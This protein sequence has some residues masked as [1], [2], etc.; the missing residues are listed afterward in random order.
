[1]RSDKSKCDHFRTEDWPKLRAILQRSIRDECVHETFR[2]NFPSRVWAFINGTLHEA[3]L[4]N[5]ETG[6]YHGFPIEY[7][8]QYPDDP[9]N[10]LSKVKS[11]SN[12]TIPIYP[13]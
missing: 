4:T 7:T 6:E 11:E 10:V 8:E 13:M 9:R 1:M 12:V 2:G 5:Q 3:R